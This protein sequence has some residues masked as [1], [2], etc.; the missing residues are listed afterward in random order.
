MYYFDLVST[1]E[2]GD[3]LG[4]QNAESISDRNMKDMTVRKERKFVLP[5]ARRP[6]GRENFMAPSVKASA[7]VYEM[8]FRIAEFSGRRNMQYAHIVIVILSLAFRQ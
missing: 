6:Y 3:A 8:A 7:E 1:R 4:A 2:P 5:I